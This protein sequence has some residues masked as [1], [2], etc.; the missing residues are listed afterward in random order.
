MKNKFD[1]TRCKKPEKDLFYDVCVHRG[2]LNGKCLLDSKQC[3]AYTGK[4]KM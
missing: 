3:L 4:L 1:Y 2:L